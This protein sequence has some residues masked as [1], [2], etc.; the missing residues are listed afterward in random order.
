[1]QRDREKVRMYNAIYISIIVLL[2][3]VFLV[4][5]Q[6]SENNAVSEFAQNNTR[7][8]EEVVSE[9]TEI[10]EIVV[11]VAGEV[12]SPGLYNVKE[13]TRTVDII[14]MAG[15]ITENADLEGVNLAKVLSDGMQ[16]KVPAKKA[17]KSSS[18]VSKTTTS[19]STSTDTGVTVINLNC[20]DKNQYMKIKGMT[21][22]VAEAII[23]Y[24]EKFGGFRSVEELRFVP[25]IDVKIYE[26]IKDSFVI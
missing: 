21:E 6:V 2:G 24:I 11:Y 17:V 8:T 18:S 16:V 14:D 26:K 1:M 7:E 12:V 9:I 20:G 4:V 23:A 15:G 22:K 3:T 19:V 10:P 13:G 5:G 25:E